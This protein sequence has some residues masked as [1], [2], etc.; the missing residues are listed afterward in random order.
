MLVPSEPVSYWC[1]N[2]QIKTAGVSGPNG[3][4]C[5]IC[6]RPLIGVDFC[7]ACQMKTST[8]PCIKCGG[9]VKISTQIER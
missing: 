6:H 3:Q 1:D 8:N 5:A 2:C 9:P 7:V 4:T